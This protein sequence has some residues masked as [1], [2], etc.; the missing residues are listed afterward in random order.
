MSLAP[1]R[2]ALRF[3]PSP[4]GYLHLGHALSALIVSAVA[5]KLGARYLL[6]I[7]DTDI[8]RARDAFVD[9]I[10][11]DLAWLGLEWEQPVVRQSQRLE[12]YKDYSDRLRQLGVLY[13]CFATRSE[14]A[15][16]ANQHDFG[17][18]PDGA[19]IY[20]LI[21]KNLD[22]ET[23]AHRIDQGEAFALRLDMDKS[24]ALV[25]QKLSGGDLC[26]ATLSAAGNRNVV[27][28]R[29]ERW[30]D[31]VLGQKGSGTSYHV[32]GVVDD[33]MSGVTHVVRGQDL[34]A[35][36]DIHRLLQVL[37]DL[38]EPI[39]HHHPLVST[40]DGRKLSK[41]AGDQSLRAL[42]AAGWSPTD[43][44]ERLKNLLRP[45]LN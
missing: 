10:L 39:Y 5:N 18:D 3:A 41:S 6:R 24:V 45:Y 13:P 16:A 8:G 33:A 37:L 27:R 32:A 9:A 1:D 25:R 19:P 28:C 26:Y 31:V 15:R 2:P 21:Y 7:E 12:V 11:E 44:V 14:I 36:T 29:P 42:R 23:A 38:P 30:G 35:A 4:N 34:E 20:P 17:V 43:V 40:D 22:P